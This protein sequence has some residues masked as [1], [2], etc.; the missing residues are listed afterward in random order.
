MKEFTDQNFINTKLS[1]AKSKLKSKPLI[2]KG[3]LQ[4]I[5]HKSKL[6]KN[7]CINNFINPLKVQEYKKYRN[8]LTKIK[9]ISKKAYYENRPYSST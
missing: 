3:I 9:T 6:Y 1:K 2:T 4:S 5:K 7:F 8:Q